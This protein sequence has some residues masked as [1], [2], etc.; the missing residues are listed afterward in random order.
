MYISFSPNPKEFED[1]SNSNYEAFSKLAFDQPTQSL[2]KYI[3]EATDN[4]NKLAE[5]LQLNVLQYKGYGKDFLKKQKLSP[6]SFV[7]MALQ[8]AFYK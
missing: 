8:Y 3:Q 2:Q 4:V 5:D 6:D 7:Q 1:G